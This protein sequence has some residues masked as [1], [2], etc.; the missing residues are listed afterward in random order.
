MWHRQYNSYSLRLH[1]PQ[2]SGSV[3]RS[4]H[5]FSH[6]VGVFSR[7]LKEHLPWS[8]QLRALDIRVHSL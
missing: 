6:G 5:L 7:Q 8:H 3:L 2:L 1:L 4:T